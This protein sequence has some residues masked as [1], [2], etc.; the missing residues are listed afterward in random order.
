MKCLSVCALPQCTPSHQQLM[1]G[2]GLQDLSITWNSNLRGLLHSLHGGMS[3]GAGSLW[4]LG[5]KGLAPSLKQ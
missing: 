1:C 2:D 5:H 4:G 3:V